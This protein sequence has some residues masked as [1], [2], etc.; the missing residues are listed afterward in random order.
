MKRAV[1]P[2]DP[3]LDRKLRPLFERSANAG[4]SR[5]P[6]WRMNQIK[7]MLVSSPKNTARQAKKLVRVLVPRDAIC[8]DIPVPDARP[9]GFQ[10]QAEAFFTFR[11]SHCLL[12][13]TSQHQV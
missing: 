4:T 12:L 10:S 7:K 3:E 13:N 1:R 9:G 5:H 6:I 2:A 11:K 8:L